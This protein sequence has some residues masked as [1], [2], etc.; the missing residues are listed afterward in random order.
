MSLCDMGR[1]CIEAGGFSR[2]IYIYIYIYMLS[3]VSCT[4]CLIEGMQVSVVK[5]VCY[6]CLAS[7]CMCMHLCSEGCLRF[8]VGV[9]VVVHL[10]SVW[11]AGCVHGVLLVFS[12]S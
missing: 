11:M 7:Y 4:F 2:F 6:S 8:S 5:C 3:V 10:S 12:V 1:S 9:I